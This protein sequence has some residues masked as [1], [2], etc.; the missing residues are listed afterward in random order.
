MKSN[1]N[2]NEKIT[3]K[4]N[5]KKEDVLTTNDLP[6]KLEQT[7]SK[8]N[9][10]VNNT[11]AILPKN[12]DDIKGNN[13]PYGYKYDKKKNVLQRETREGEWKIFFRSHLSVKSIYINSETN[14]TNYELAWIDHRGKERTTIQ[15][16]NVCSNSRKIV[17]LADLGLQITSS[18]SK[19]V[20]EYIDEYKH[21]A[22]NEIDVKYFIERLGYHKKSFVMPHET[23]NKKDLIFMPNSEGDKQYTEGFSKNGTLEEW[24][25]NIFDRVKKYPYAMMFLMSSFAS[26]LLEKFNMKPFIVEISGNTSLG[27]TISMEVASTVWG[28]PKTL[29]EKWNTTMTAVGRRAGL[30]RNLP[31]FLDDTKNGVEKMIHSI[32]YQFTQGVE[33]TRGNL[34]GTQT[35]QTWS[36]IMLSTGEKKI[37][38]FGHNAG[39]AGRV[40]T[41]NKA[42]FGRNNSELVD[43][44]EFDMCEYYG[45]AGIAFL[46]WLMNEEIAIWKERYKLLIEEYSKMANGNNVIKRLSKNM[47]LI[48][49]TSLMVNEALQVDFEDSLL[50]DLWKEMIETNKEIDKPRQAME[51]LYE[52]CLMNKTQFVYGPECLEIKGA[53][54]D[55][56]YNNSKC[57]RIAMYPSKVK[58]LLENMGYDANTIINEWN[59]KGWLKASEKRTTIAVRLILGGVKKMIVIDTDIIKQFI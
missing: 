40:L 38:E 53:W 7:S 57:N 36:N 20:V 19:E 56:E 30:L 39:V 5:I 29:I 6:Q 49:I 15:S 28:D 22:G 25:K 41:I 3:I 11:N 47:A 21:H 14:K 31:L 58:E 59:N 32:V 2:Q 4:N 9:L 48:H 27:K 55:W 33:K 37:T 35:A 12:E 42:P 16:A 50:Y 45:T 24:K 13:L 1:S 18:N 52:Q 43:L 26:V 10:V 44:L 51:D 23:I 54:G 34:T 46:E 17:E 8:L